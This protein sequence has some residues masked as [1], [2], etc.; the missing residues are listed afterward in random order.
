MKFRWPFNNIKT[1]HWVGINLSALAPSAVIY[2]DEG[3]VDAVAYDQEQGIE[4]LASWIKK[5]VSHEMPTVLVLDDDDYELLLAEAPDVP[6]EELTA[7]IE[8]QNW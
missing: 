5:Y 2:S 4:A 3:V 6:D 1:K 8:F 7:A